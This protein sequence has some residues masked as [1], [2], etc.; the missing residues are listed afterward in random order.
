MPVGIDHL[1][2]SLKEGGYYHL[3]SALEDPRSN[4]LI[5]KGAYKGF[6]IR[7]V[8]KDLS[9]KGRGSLDRYLAEIKREDIH[10]FNHLLVTLQDMHV[11]SD[12]DERFKKEVGKVYFEVYEKYTNQIREQGRKKIASGELN[13]A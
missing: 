13:N 6:I 3:A 4:N 2:N 5:G 10:P 7:I 9:E 11:F 12:D 1:V 8:I